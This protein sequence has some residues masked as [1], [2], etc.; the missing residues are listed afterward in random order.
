MDESNRTSI[1]WMKMISSIVGPKRCSF[2][3]ENRPAIIGN[4]KSVE[5]VAKAV[6]QMQ[7][8]PIEET[9]INLIHSMGFIS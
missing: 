3:D 9:D 2:S 6:S 5:T 8:I 4:R 7:R 1:D